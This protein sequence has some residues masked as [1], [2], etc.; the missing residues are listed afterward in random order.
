M[1][2]YEF[3]I[4]AK[5]DGTQLKTELDCDDVYIRGDKLII[6]GDL[7]QAQAAAGIAAHQPIDTYAIKQA[8]KA[9]LLAKLGITEAEARLLMGGN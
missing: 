3:A 5:L 2:F 7:T 9:A 1:N 8:D 6:G 4:P